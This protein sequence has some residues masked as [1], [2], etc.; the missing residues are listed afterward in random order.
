MKLNNIIPP[1]LQQ[2]VTNTLEQMEKQ[3]RNGRKTENF[4]K[5]T[6]AW[7]SQHMV[8]INYHYKDELLERTVDPYFIEP[9]GLGH[10]H[11]LIAYCHLKES[12]EVFKIDN[13]SGDV[14]ICPD[15]YEIPS[16][17]HAIDYLSHSWG[18][19]IDDNELITVK[20]HFSRKSNVMETIWH[21]SQVVQTQKDGS[22]ILTLRVRN[23]FDFR[24]WV[25][26]WGVEAEVLEP[27]TLRNQ[28]IKHAQALLEL[29]NLQNPM[30]QSNF[31]KPLNRLYK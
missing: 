27:E 6:E 16:D 24:Q 10:S 20:I 18:V 26:G 5:L 14:H 31:R 12:I 30:K 3:P 11:Y 25:L 4:N 7:L 22:V 13:I 19:H 28:I 15:T 2:Q 23:T 21:P 1:P 8:K 29:Y 17:F 9:S